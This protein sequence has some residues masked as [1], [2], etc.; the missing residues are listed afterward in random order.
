MDSLNNIISILRPL[1]LYSLKEDSLVMCEL[2]AEAVGLEKLRLA[3]EELISEAFPATASGFGLK[4]LE[5]VIN[6]GG[7]PSELSDR[8][9]R[10]LGSL[11]LSGRDKT[12]D[13]IKRSLLLFGVEAEITENFADEKLVI[14]GKGWRLPYVSAQDIADKLSLIL[15]AHLGAD[16]SVNATTWSFI[17]SLRRNFGTWDMGVYT[18]GELAEIGIKTCS[19]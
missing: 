19:V 17:H 18:W 5:R 16:I 3:M 9:R 2:K 7:I 15:P 8:R 12:I 14:T 1:G 6:L 11:A 4:I 13:G 10:L